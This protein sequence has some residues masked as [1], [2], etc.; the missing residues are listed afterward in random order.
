MDWSFLRRKVRGF[1]DVLVVVLFNIFVGDW[2]ICR[3]YYVVVVSETDK[4]TFRLALSDEQ[5]E[6]VFE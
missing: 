3:G 2:L 1:L 4:K 6:V 5:A